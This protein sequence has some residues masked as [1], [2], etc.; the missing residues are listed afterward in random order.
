MEKKDVRTQLLK[1]VKEHPIPPRTTEHYDENTNNVPQTYMGTQSSGR[2][3]YTQNPSMGTQTLEGQGYRQTLQ[4]Q[5]YS[6]NDT[7]SQV[8]PV[9]T[10]GHMGYNPLRIA[11][12]VTQKEKHFRQYE[13]VPGFDKQLGGA[14]LAECF[15]SWSINDPKFNQCRQ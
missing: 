14:S 1:Y 10:S 6:Q 11:N 4:G 2:Q 5:G 3:G 9:T 13:D 15:G 8:M 7:P 12:N